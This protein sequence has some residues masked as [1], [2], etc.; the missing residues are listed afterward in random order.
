MA[1][2][3]LGVRFNRKGVDRSTMEQPSTEH[4]FKY[5]VHANRASDGKAQHYT[6]AATWELRPSDDQKCIAGSGEPRADRGKTPK[7]D[8]H[9]RRK[10][11]RVGARRQPNPVGRTSS[12]EGSVRFPG[13][14]QLGVQLR[15][16]REAQQGR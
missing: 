14:R 8:R 1:I 15:P 7:T 6:L 9:H 4:A 5:D 3:S 2:N 11:R 13:S 12:T 16:P 10:E